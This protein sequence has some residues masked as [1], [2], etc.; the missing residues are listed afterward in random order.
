MTEF[1]AFGAFHTAARGRREHADSQEGR[2]ARRFAYG[3]KAEPV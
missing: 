2:E 3:E 1:G